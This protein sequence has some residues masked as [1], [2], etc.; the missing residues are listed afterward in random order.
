M[1][2]GTGTGA[3]NTGIRHGSTTGYVTYRCRCDKCRAAWAEYHRQKRQENKQRQW[4]GDEP[5]HGTAAGAD[6]YRCSCR[7]CKTFRADYQKDRQ[8]RKRQ[9]Q[10]EARV[11]GTQEEK[12]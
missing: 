7:R 10:H 4:T 5:W 6:Y 11:K 3:S 9:E 12:G 1:E 2:V 8:Q